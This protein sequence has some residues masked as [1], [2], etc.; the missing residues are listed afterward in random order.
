MRDPTSPR[1]LYLGGGIR[2]E[3][4]E[5]QRNVPGIHQMMFFIRGT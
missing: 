3:A 1:K 2:H 4:D 5:N